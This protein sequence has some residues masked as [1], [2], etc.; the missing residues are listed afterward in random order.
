MFVHHL[1]LEQQ[2]ALLTTAERLIASDEVIAKEEK[3]IIEILKSQ[4]HSNLPQTSDFELRALEGLLNT[5]QSKVSFMLELIGVA[6]VDNEYHENE[7]GFIQEV[8]GIIN[9]DNSL[10]EKL[11]EWVKQQVNLLASA[12]EMMEE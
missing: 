4:M 7:R 5:N 10:L 1:N 6:L 11:E 8:A 2:A 9:M 12:A 3:S